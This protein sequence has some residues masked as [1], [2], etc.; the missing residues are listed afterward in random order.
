MVDNCSLKRM[1]VQTNKS[2]YNNNTIQFQKHPQSPTHA[3]GAITDTALKISQ[4]TNQ[5]NDED[6]FDIQQ[7]HT[8]ATI[9]LFPPLPPLLYLVMR[10]RFF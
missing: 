8:D 9:K 7:Q 1:K 4:I 6:E 3:I 2:P 5:A 10:R